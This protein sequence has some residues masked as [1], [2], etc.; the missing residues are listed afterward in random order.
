MKTRFI[1]FM[2]LLHIFVF[3][4]VAFAQNYRCNGKLIRKGSTKVDPIKNC[5]EPD[6]LLSIV[7]SNRGVMVK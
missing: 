4:T 2:A 5:G 6:R 1:V 3:G 7:S